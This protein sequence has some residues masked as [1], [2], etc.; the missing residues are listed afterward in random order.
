MSLARYTSTMTTP[1][2]SSAAGS[3]APATEAS[4]SSETT[5]TASAQLKLTPRQAR[6]LAWQSGFLEYLFRERPNQLEVYNEIR[7]RW[8]EHEQIYGLVIHRQYG[9]SRMGCVLCMEE[10]L[11][12]A[13][14]RRQKA[15]INGVNPSISKI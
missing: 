8:D 5:P 1:P 9:K 15:G 14:R 4:D 3:A 11:R 7:R 12:A 10:C 6:V 13:S 2:D